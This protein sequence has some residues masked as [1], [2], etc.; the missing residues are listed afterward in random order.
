MT[1]AHANT[2]DHLFKII[3]E[4]L[5]LLEQFLSVLKQEK[6]ALARMDADAIVA[7]SEQKSALIDQI[8]PSTQSLQAHLP[9]GTSLQH[10]LKV[11]A[12]SDDTLQTLK[13]FI[14]VSEA[15]QALHL[16]N[17][18]TLTRLAQINEGFLALLAGRQA[19]P[20]YAEKLGRKSSARSPQGGVLGKA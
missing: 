1:H 4:L 2:T 5:P 8:S 10:Y 17:G 12:S 13:R 9:D 19:D 16:E 11:H 15:A 18:L 6:D 7:L 14:E 3:D 20:T